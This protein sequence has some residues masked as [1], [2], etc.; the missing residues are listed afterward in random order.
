MNF[1]SY[2][3]LALIIFLLGL[4]VLH[5][6]WNH[7]A[8]DLSTG[9][10]GNM[11]KTQESSPAAGSTDKGMNSAGNNSQTGMDKGMGNNGDNRQ[12]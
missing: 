6:G 11:M 8:L 4:A 7:G 1:R 9:Q 12:K 10:C 2:L 3:W 5:Q